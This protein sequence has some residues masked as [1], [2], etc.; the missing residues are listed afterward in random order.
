MNVTPNSGS[1]PAPLISP[2]AD[3]TA[4]TPLTRR[5]P[6]PA[7]PRAALPPVFAA[8]AA[9]A[10]TDRKND[11]TAEGTRL[12]A[13]GQKR[14][15]IWNKDK[16]DKNSGFT[17]PMVKNLMIFLG[18]AKNSHLRVYNLDT[19]IK[20]IEDYMAILNE[21]N[22][23]ALQ[24]C[25]DE[26]LPEER[27][28]Y[29]ARR[30][31][32]TPAHHSYG[33]GGGGGGADTPHSDYSTRSGRLRSRS[34]ITS[35]DESGRS[36]SKSPRRS[37][38]F[39][40]TP[41]A[42]GAP[43]PSPTAASASAAAAESMALLN[44]APMMPPTAPPALITPSFQVMQAYV[45]AAQQQLQDT[46]QMVQMRTALSAQAPMA[47][48]L[49]SYGNDQKMAS[50]F[51]IPS[52]IALP[53]NSGGYVMTMPPYYGFLAVP[54]PF[55]AQPPAPPALPLPPQSVPLAPPSAIPN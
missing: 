46:V 15:S 21:K 14:V 55:Y 38:S 12:Y 43:A 54:I 53:P 34:P 37:R 2:N 42:T 40:R 30:N 19:N 49:Q 1:A 6:R 17:T 51:P 31:T 41:E 11:E 39:S 20:I 18:K 45:A 44:T 25:I 8:G 27:V 36:R 9:A 33:R 22:R 3:N 35:D 52:P 23:L 48:V 4:A 26:A 16:N 50:G 47:S 24:I 32:S 13:L 5:I 29:G 7:L 10:A 28:I